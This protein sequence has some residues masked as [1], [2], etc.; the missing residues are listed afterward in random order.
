MTE[1]FFIYLGFH[2]FLMKT[3]PLFR[4]N[5]F[6]R[7]QKDREEL[8]AFLDFPVQHRQTIRTSN[9]IESAFASIRHRTKRSKE[10]LTRGGMLHMMFKL[11]Q[12]A[13]Q[14]WRKLR[15]FECLAKVITGVTFKDGIEATNL[16]Q[17]TA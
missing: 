11:G 9:L 8:T 4:T 14:N 2:Y 16:D 17:I 15:K 7:L 3:R 6:L 1:C 10:Y 5:C 12:C 13:D